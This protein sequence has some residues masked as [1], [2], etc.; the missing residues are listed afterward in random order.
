[1]SLTPAVKVSRR[2]AEIGREAWDACAGNPA[3]DANPFIRFDFLDALEEANCAI[4]RTGWGPQHLS[5]ADEDGRVAAVM[6]LYL[7]SHSQGE[8]V[9]DHAWADAYERAG[10]QY[11]PKLLSAAPFTPATGA[12]LLARPD[13]DEGEARR[14]L[15]GGGLTLCER[16]GASGLNLNFLTESEWQWMGE[17][18]L[19]ES[20]LPRLRGLP[21]RALV[22]PPQDHPSRAPG[23]P[24]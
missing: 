3:Y 7:K 11:Y 14:L 8:Y 16:Y 12:R 17:Q 6:P 23:R 4:E 10:G 20:G 21:G 24:S 15:L 9:F 13:V 1:V 5:V 2:I 18:G 19:A 22:R